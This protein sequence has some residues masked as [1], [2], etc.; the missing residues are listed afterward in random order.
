MIKLTETT[1][2]KELRNIDKIEGIESI[3]ITLFTGYN[4]TIGNFEGNDNDLSSYI[5]ISVLTLDNEYVCIYESDFLKAGD[6][7]T[8]KKFN[9]VCN[10]I[11]K[12]NEFTEYEIKTEITTI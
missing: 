6:K 3:N 7:A 2:K 4:S 1:F 9:S 10:K 12:W 8:L 5:D 11:N